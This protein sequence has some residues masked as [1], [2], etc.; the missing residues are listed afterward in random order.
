MVP[1]VIDDRQRP[2]ERGAMPAIS[3]GFGEHIEVSFL[4]L[5]PFAPSLYGNA[6]VRV[7]RCICIS[8]T[9]IQSVEFIGQRWLRKRLS[10]KM[11]PQRRRSCDQNG[12]FLIRFLL[13]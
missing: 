5:R 13:D 4:N 1:M 6:R 10:C 11:S 9:G 12:D 7:N 3:A 2:F 8:F